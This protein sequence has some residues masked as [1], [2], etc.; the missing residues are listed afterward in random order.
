[1]KPL[2]YQ[3]S[4]A[5]REAKKK[6]VPEMMDLIKELALFEKE[7]EAVTVSLKDFE[8]AGFGDKPVWEAFVAETYD[9][10]H[11]RYIIC[12]IALYYI[13]YSTWKGKMMYLEDIVV[14]Q[15]YRG[16]GIGS[17]LINQLLEA[18]KQK[19]LSGICW[20]VLAWNKSA[21]SFYKKTKDVTFDNDWINV[22][23]ML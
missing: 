12:G 1:M 11:Q 15:N 18:A 21:I 19:K 13:R 4:I 20:Q 3:A 17:Q 10:V 5:I 9:E 23:I 8:D 2:G 6:D 14:N 16:K 7:P 22:K